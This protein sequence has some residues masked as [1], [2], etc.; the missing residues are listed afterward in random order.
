MAPPWW[1]SFFLMVSSLDPHGQSIHSLRVGWRNHRILGS[2][3]QCAN[4]TPNLTYGEITVI[5]NL[6]NFYEN[7]YVRI[8][9]CA[10]SFPCLRRNY[11]SFPTYLI[12][13]RIMTRMKSFRKI[14]QSQFTSIHIFL[15]IFHASIVGVIEFLQNN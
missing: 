2:S 15:R 1:C 5:P 13:T 14:P 4:S 10:T 11:G 7:H 9:F 3:R 8:L 12:F 6:R